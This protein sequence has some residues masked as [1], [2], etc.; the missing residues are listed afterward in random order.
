MVIVQVVHLSS[1]NICFKSV[2]YLLTY[3][4]TYYRRQ[5]ALHGGLVMAKSGR[6]ELG[7]NIY[8]QYRSIFKH[9][10][11]FGQNKGYYAVQGHTRSSRSVPIESPYVTSY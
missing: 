4:L 7:D 2:I 8:G 3:L 6:L 1:E 5:T 10:D 9:C 11:V